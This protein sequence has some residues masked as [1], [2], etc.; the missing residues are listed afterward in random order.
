MSRPQFS[1][2]TLLW[3]MLVVASFFGGLV[4]GIRLER[5]RLNAE[6]AAKRERELAAK[7]AELMIYGGRLPVLL[8]RRRAPASVPPT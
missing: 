5:L 6:L 3:L 4:I 8:W 1:L 7:K 2:K